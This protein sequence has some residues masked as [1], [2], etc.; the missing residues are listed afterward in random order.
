MLSLFGGARKKTKTTKRRSKST[1]RRSKSTKR[2]SNSTKKKSNST[3][4][5]SKTRKKK[6]KSRKKK[7]KSRKKKSKSRKRKLTKI[8]LFYQDYD[9]L[10]NELVGIHDTLYELGL[11]DKHIKHQ[12]G[13]KGPLRKDKSFG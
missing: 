11:K 7:S 12:L 4:K 5:K 9:I 2:R 10:N 13:V 3:K 8:P 1:K 6:S